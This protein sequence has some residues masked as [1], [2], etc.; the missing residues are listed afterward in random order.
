MA[1]QWSHYFPKKIQSSE[2]SILQRKQTT[3][4]KNDIDNYDMRAEEYRPTIGS[5]TSFAVEVL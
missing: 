2:F 3:K 1:V 4:A 5:V